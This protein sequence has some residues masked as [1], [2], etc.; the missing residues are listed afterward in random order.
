MPNW[1]HTLWQKNYLEDLEVDSLAPNSEIQLAKV[2][3]FLRICCVVSAGQKKKPWPGCICRISDF[4][5]QHDLDSRWRDSIFRVAGCLIF[6]L[7]PPGPELR[8][9]MAKTTF[10]SW[11][12]PTQSILHRTGSLTSIIIWYLQ[13]G[14]L[15]WNFTHMLL[16]LANCFWDRGN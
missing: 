12:R 8:R 15:G 7:Y 2:Q 9:E 4:C 3:L 5:R 1:L 13:T 11:G 10:K 16:Q 6:W 14:V